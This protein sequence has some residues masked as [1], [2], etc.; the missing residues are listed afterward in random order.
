MHSLNGC[1]RGLQGPKRST[2]AH[3]VTWIF[4]V[5]LELYDVGRCYIKWIRK[6]VHQGWRLKMVMKIW[7]LDCWFFIA[8]QG[9]QIYSLLW[10]SSCIQRS[11]SYNVINLSNGLKSLCYNVEK[12]VFPCHTKLLLMQNWICLYI[13]NLQC[14]M[15]FQIDNHYVRSL[16]NDF[17]CCIFIHDHPSDFPYTN[18]TS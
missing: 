5:K 18:G 14:L 3:N 15:R 6:L 13:F 4:L 1:H 10:W 17:I 7:K 9:Q 11:Q 2:L 16:I 8:T 12:K